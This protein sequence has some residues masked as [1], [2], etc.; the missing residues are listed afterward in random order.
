[1]SRDGLIWMQST[2]L[3][4]MEYFNTFGGNPVSCAIGMAAFDVIDEENLQEN[5]FLVGKQL[6]SDLKKLQ[7]IRAL[8]GDVR[9]LGRFVGI[10]LVRDPNSLEPAAE[11]A[12]R[13]VNMMKKR[14]I[15]IST[16]SAL[17]NV[18]K[19]KPPLPFTRSDA[20]RLVNTLDQ[21]L[22]LMN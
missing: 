11:E 10:E 20:K 6:L 17:N 22:N 1:M 3:T 21:I 2:I 13:I 9:G 8:M 14:G 16:D 12:T 4:G 7:E 15:L 5:A 19:I 18:L